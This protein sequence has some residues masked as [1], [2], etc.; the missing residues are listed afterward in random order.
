MKLIFMDLDGTLED[1]RQDMSEAVNSVR[2]Y[3]DLQE[4]PPESIAPLVT[5]GMEHLYRNCFP[6][7]FPGGAKPLAFEETEVLTQLQKSYEAD[8]KRNVA[9]HTVAY[10]GIKESLARLADIGVLS[11]YTNKPA[12]ISRKLLL[13][14]ELSEY[15]SFVVGCETFEQTKPSP[16]PMQVIAKDAEFNP[17]EDTCFMIGDSAGDM[18]AAQA[19]DAV[20]IWCAWGYYDT[21]PEPAPM[22]TAEKPED[23]PRLLES[24]QP[25]K[26]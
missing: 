14:L 24:F 23:L 8:Y 21:A 17:A 26:T 13:E 19:F 16:L 5:K 3:Y 18:Q 2:T 15:F 25:D 9:H 20:S 12:H 10:P 6:E 4:M 1:S 22:F 11:I 7:L